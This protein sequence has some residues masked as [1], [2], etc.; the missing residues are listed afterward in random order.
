MAGDG[1]QATNEASD[2]WGSQHAGQ[3]LKP[4]AEEHI[5]P[6]VWLTPPGTSHTFI[7]KEARGPPRG[8]C[9]EQVCRA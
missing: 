2:L 1:T 5:W 3:A 9:V 7:F 8:A 6:L 4:T